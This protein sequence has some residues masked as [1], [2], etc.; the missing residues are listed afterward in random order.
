MSLEFSYPSDLPLSE[1]RPRILAALRQHQVVVISGATG[2][3]KTTQLPKMCLEVGRGTRGM[4]GHTQ[5]RRLAARTVASRIASEL[6]QSL[7][8]TVGYQVRFRQTLGPETQIKLM[9][10]GILLAEIS[11]DPLLK[12][13]DALIIDEAHERSLNNDFILGYLQRLVVKRPDLLVIITSA[14]IDSER[15]ATAFGPDTPIIEVAGRTYP[16]EVRYRPLVDIDDGESGAG[17][18]S[19]ETSA[20]TE[21]GEIDQVTGILRA[22]DE[23]CREGPGDILVFLAGERDI[24]DTAQALQ[25]HLGRRYVAPG[26]RTSVPGAVEVLP[27][28]SRLSETEQKRVFAPHPYRRVVLATNVAETSLTVPGI[29]YVVDPGVARISR[30]SNK[31]RVQRLPIEPISQASAN[32]RKGR[33]G[34]VAP[35]ICIRLYSEADFLSR[36]AYTEPEIQRTSLSSVILQMAALGLGEVADFPFLDPP[37]PRSVTDGVTELSQLGALDTRQKPA[38]LTRLGRKLS[39]FPL[40]PRLARILVEADH[41][42]V[43]DLAVVVVAALAM[44]DVRERPTERRTE[45]DLAHARFEDERSDFLGYLKLWSYLQDRIEMLSASA[46]R[47][48]CSREFFHFL[49]V[50]EWIDLVAELRGMCRE[51]G[52]KTKEITEINLDQVDVERLHQAILSGMLTQIGFWSETKR[53]YRGAH[54]T[55]FVVWPGS[56]L[57]HKHYDWV[58]A[59]ELVETSRL[60]ARTVAKVEPEWIERAGR[61]L[62]TRTYFDPYWS[63]RFGCAMIHERVSLFGMVLSADRS[64]P[65]ASLHDTVVEGTPARTLARELFIRHGIVRGEWRSVYP[66]R[67]ENQRRLEMAAEARRRRQIPGEVD[68]YSL[69]K[70]LET[71]IDPAVTSGAAFEAWWKDQR[72]KH[73]DWLEYPW[74]LLVP[75]NGENADQFPDFWQA[76]EHLLPLAYTFSGKRGPTPEAANRRNASGS[77]GKKSQ[78]TTEREIDTVDLPEGVTIIIDEA[79]LE[80]V[81]SQGFDWP[82][83]GALRDY[84]LT[85]VKA[86]PKAVR[87][88]VVPAAN[89]VDEIL[90]RFEQFVNEP[91]QERPNFDEIFAQGVTAVRHVDL[92]ETDL[93]AM[94]AAM[95]ESQRNHFAIVG[96]GG[97]V[98]ALGDD[99]QALRDRLIVKTTQEQG[100]VW[101]QQEAEKAKVERPRDFAQ[102]LSQALCLTET[103]VS[104][105]WRGVEA[106]ALA[107]SPYPSTSA[108]IAAAQSAAGRAL[109]EEYLAEGHPLTDDSDLAKLQEWAIDR[110]EDQVYRILQAVVSAMQSQG[111]LE[112]QLRNATGSSLTATKADIVNHVNQLVGGDFLARTPAKWLPQLARYLRADTLRL[113]KA[114]RNSAGDTQLAARFAEVSTAFDAVAV[115]VKARPF[116]A[117]T[118]LRLQEL[119]WLLEEYRVQTF[120]Q[121]LGTIEKVSAKRI[122]KQILALK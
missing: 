52:I 111:E 19:E 74:D 12:Q 90:P 50:R 84:L 66:F 88:Y 119:R 71:R 62:L 72:L 109:V 23:L 97:K 87:K 104:T 58:M 37:S 73:P 26:Q 80:S 55:R 61:Y 99:F 20:I 70:W 13:Y 94:H 43:I 121:Q 100:K 118:H 59:A 82:I 110:Y 105:R 117:E 116:N 77:K 21:P 29:I 25:G 2:S 32:Q 42:G 24:R 79:I 35:G 36:P 69:E 108:L 51:V 47:R 68:P 98:L 39:R 102:Q 28:Y 15:F 16:V 30:Y 9:T 44:Q 63:T 56:G 22:V 115:A 31:T 91:P 27:L 112:Q 95:E 106:A 57:S 86:L 120:A 46:F 40:D 65:L 11:H 34:R 18:D 83:P 93:V 101:A 107:A 8:S 89:F 17:D 48:L 78:K 114:R 96:R 113:D 81:N 6:G 3:G 14:T 60:F 4:I 5:P 64:L 53:E 122:N 10:D 76:G 54:G 49:R 85:C 7:G 41:L 38:R 92:T 75:D 33:C 1:A 67:Q 45:A 103:R